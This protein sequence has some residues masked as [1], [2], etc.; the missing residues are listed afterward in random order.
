A[1]IGEPGMMTA[2]AQQL[3]AACAAD[4][5]DGKRADAL[6]TAL[7]DEGLAPFQAAQRAYH[8]AAKTFEERAI[9]DAKRGHAP[10]DLERQLT[11]AA[12]K[13]QPEIFRKWL[14]AR[15]DQDPQLA[16]LRD[17]Y[18]ETSP[19]VPAA[20]A[21][22]TVKLTRARAASGA[23]KKRLLDQTENLFL[24][25]RDAAEG[26]AT[27]HLLLAQVDHRLGKIKE[28]D[29]Q[30]ALLLQRNDA[31]TS[32]QVASTLRDLGLRPKARKVAED[33]YAMPGAAEGLKSAAASLR[34]H[35]A[36]DL[37]DEET[38]LKRVDSKDSGTAELLA[39]LGAKR[40]LMKG[41]LG[42]ADRAFAKIAAAREAR[43]T[44]DATAAN[45]ASGAYMGRY[46]ATG[47]LAHVRSAVRLLD[48]AITLLPDAPIPIENAAAAH[49]QLGMALVLDKWVQ[50]KTLAIGE[51]D[52]TSLARALLLGS[53]RDALLEALGKEPALR[54]S[55]D[56]AR[57]VQV[58]APQ[59]VAPYD[60][61]LA[62]LAWAGDAAGLEAMRDRLAKLPPFDAFGVTDQRARWARGDDDAMYLRA[63]ESGIA[64]AEQRVQRAKKAGHKPTIAAACWLLADAYA[65]RITVTERLDDAS[66]RSGSGDAAAMAAAGKCAVET[67]PE[68]R[69]EPHVAGQ[70]VEVALLRAAQ[71]SPVVARA[72]KADFRRLSLANVVIRAMSGADGAAFTAALRARPE[73]A[74]AVR[75]TK[76]TARA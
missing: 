28:A 7:V 29:E 55:L 11:G 15:F 60:A 9:D 33:V 21:L 26:E 74:E 14:R 2:A 51:T 30:F 32:L 16:A 22:G 66:A 1:A 76:I 46:F 49:Q 41:D 69:L 63:A 47:D 53:M 71:T 23:E 25:I 65:S 68:A 44:H 20:L 34:A 6:L 48:S 45:N 36:D 19:V 75:L 31:Q 13:D 5:G 18:V 17:A 4:A 37:E 3:L 50:M 43:A 35:M 40:S 57:Q 62:R 70:L 8:A 39:E 12:E 59:N 10:A 56:L 73:L 61:E 54:R 72:M 64:L 24:S 58:L 67:W 42:E 52:A 38:W 27:F